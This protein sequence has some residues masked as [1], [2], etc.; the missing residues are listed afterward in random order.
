[1][2]IEAYLYLRNRMDKHHALIQELKRIKNTPQLRTEDTSH[3]ERTKIVLEGIQKILA[4]SIR[5]ITLDYDQ[6]K[7]TVDHGWTQLGLDST[8]PRE[9][10][11][12]EYPDNNL[13]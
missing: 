10:N 6:L 11:D 5:V 8:D 1:M 3:E 12:H 4:E 9:D 7:I 13:E 2:D